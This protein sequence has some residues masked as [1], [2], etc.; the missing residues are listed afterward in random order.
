MNRKDQNFTSP[1]IQD[2]ILKEMSLSILHVIVDSIKNADFH[3]IMVNETSNLS[4]K[5]Q[6]VFCDR[7]V[8]ENLF[9]YKDFLRLHE[10]EKT[11]AISIAN[12]IKGTILRLGFDSEKLRGKC[13]DDCATEMGKKKGIAT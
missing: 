7:G 5:E 9:S 6:A 3:S 13:Y 2:D 11:D 8:D 10:M 12:F 1:D 4:D